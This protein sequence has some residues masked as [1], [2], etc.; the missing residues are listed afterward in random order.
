MA[1]ASHRRRSTSQFACGTLQQER[2]SRLLDT[3]TGSFL[4]H[5][6]QMDSA[7]HQPRE[8][9]RIA[10]DSTTGEV[11]AVPFTAPALCVAF[12]PDGKLIASGLGDRTIR[13]WDAVTGDI[14]AGPFS[15]HT[16]WVIHIAFSPDGQRIASTSLDGTCRVWDAT[17]GEV[18]AG[19]FTEQTDFV[20]SCSVSFSTD[21]GSA[22]LRPREITRFACGTSQQEISQRARLLDI[23][24]TSTLLRSRQMENTSRQPQTIAWFVYGTP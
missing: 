14:V 8:I 24:M 11:V 4:L 13:V 16:H 21:M 23:P 17:T 10:W 18:I 3:P 1:S 22:S 6:H 9:T 12:S 7:S 19:P 2:S 20:S 5:S 15:G